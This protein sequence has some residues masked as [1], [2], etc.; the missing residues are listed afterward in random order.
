MNFALGGI[1]L[2]CILTGVVVTHVYGFI[3]IPKTEQL[4]WVHLTVCTLCLTKVYLILKIFYNQQALRMV[5]KLKEKK[6]KNP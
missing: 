3:K 4:Q 2:S 1:E 6:E 5:Y